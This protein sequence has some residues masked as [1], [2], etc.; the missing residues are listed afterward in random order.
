MHL[1]HLT[2]FWRACREV[3]FVVISNFSSA[4]F[5]WL[6]I[7]LIHLFMFFLLS[8]KILEQIEPN[9]TLKKSH[10]TLKHPLVISSNCYLLIVQYVNQYEFMFNS[11]KYFSKVS[12]FLLTSCGWHILL[13]LGTTK[14]PQQNP[15]KFKINLYHPFLDPMV[16][17]LNTTFLTNIINIGHCV[18]KIS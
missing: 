16:T 12:N 5:F 6:H 13:A 10:F 3:G 11:L 4:F 2:C 17:H 14:I 7:I 9:K 15:I 8:L 18:L 1:S